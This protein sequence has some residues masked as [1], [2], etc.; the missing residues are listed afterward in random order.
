MSVVNETARYI[1]ES[2]VGC[3]NSPQ[4]LLLRFF[5]LL[6][7]I[8]VGSMVLHGIG[9]GFAY[10]IIYTWAL[11]KWIYYKFKGKTI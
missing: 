10:P 8:S 6:G 2:T 11:I 5:A 9:K 4:E 1:V 3:S 7:L